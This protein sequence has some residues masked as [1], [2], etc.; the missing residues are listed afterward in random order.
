MLLGMIVIITETPLDF[1]FEI[2]VV[3]KIYF[4]FKTNEATQ[5][6]LYQVLIL[7]CVERSHYVCLYLV[8]LW[9][10]II[11]W[12]DSSEVKKNNN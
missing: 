11:S 5:R 9:P 10:S 8:Y 12:S 1:L 7:V 3:L 2:V 6:T 4:F